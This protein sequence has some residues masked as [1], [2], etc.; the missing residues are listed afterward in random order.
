MP[1]DC[2]R[3]LIRAKVQVKT[4]VLKCRNTNVPVP[5]KSFDG[6]SPAFAGLDGGWVGGGSTK[7]LDSN[8]F[9]L[10]RKTSEILSFA[11]PPPPSVG[12]YRMLTGSW[13]RS[14][15]HSLI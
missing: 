11:P 14:E 1:A 15:S 6:T 13:G 12:S 3:S 9:A 8:S 7:W 2:C 5:C 10:A 4:R